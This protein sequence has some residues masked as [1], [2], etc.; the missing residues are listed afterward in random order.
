MALCLGGRGAVADGW[1]WSPEGSGFPIVLDSCSLK[2]W[3]PPSSPGN[4]L[5]PGPRD[6]GI[7][8]GEGGSPA[9]AL[10]S[11]AAC[12]PGILLLRDGK[13][14]SG[15]QLI[16][17]LREEEGPRDSFLHPPPSIWGRALLSSGWGWGGPGQ[18]SK[19]PS[20]ALEPSPA[21]RGHQGTLE[22]EGAWR[23]RGEVGVGF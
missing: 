18:A 15:L 23:G 12:S 13:S 11:P 6:P 5:L 2:F 4:P 20:H 19:A 1:G 8:A 22:A 21:R 9:G 3:G 10:P 14:R 16:P 17:P 7:L